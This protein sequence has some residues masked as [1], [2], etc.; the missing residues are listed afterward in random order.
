M[1]LLEWRRRFMNDWEAYLAGAS[2]QVV[3]LGLADTVR[4]AAAGQQE[5]DAASLLVVRPACAPGSLPARIQNDGSD[6][7][8]GGGS[9]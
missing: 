7:P 3:V 4:E 1:D 5:P 8:N 9:V 6:P 2:R